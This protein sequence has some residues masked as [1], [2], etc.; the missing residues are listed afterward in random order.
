MWLF[1]REP[2]AIA[3]SALLADLLGSLL[4]SLLLFVGE[5]LGFG[6]Y[7]YHVDLDRGIRQAD[8]GRSLTLHLLFGFFAA[9]AGLFVILLYTIP[10]M[11]VLRKFRLGGPLM[12]LSIGMLPG[13]LILALERK[14]GFGFL[15]IV[16]GLPVVLVFCALAYRQHVL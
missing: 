6:T 8:F 9:W 15:F 1:T 11:V 4:A 10:V 5:Q 2:K 3:R 14:L 16:F 7:T 12:A 13:V